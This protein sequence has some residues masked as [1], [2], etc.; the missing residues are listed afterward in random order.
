[1]SYGQFGTG[2]IN[3]MMGTQNDPGIL[4]FLLLI[5]SIINSEKNINY[6]SY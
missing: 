3:T 4:Y 1:M 6:K 5:S 2:K